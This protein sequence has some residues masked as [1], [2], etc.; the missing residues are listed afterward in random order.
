MRPYQPRAI[1][2]VPLVLSLAGVATHVSAQATQSRQASSSQ[3]ATGAQ[4]AKPL[5]VVNL[6]T[7]TAAE[8]EALP[9]IGA[10]TAARIID[11]R[12]KK[13]PF[14]KIE[15]IMNVQGIGEKS[16]LKLK[17]QITVSGN[18]AAPAQ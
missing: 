9:G 7:A 10:K 4:S 13:G 11:Y 12:Q 18:S 14:K 6:N 16:F 17:P 5:V 15:E 3:P 8:L 1:A 2:I